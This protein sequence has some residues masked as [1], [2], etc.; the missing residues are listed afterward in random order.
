MPRINS[1]SQTY[2]NH[3]ALYGDKTKCFLIGA[4]VGGGLA[5]S[6]AL[7]LVELGMRSS[8]I[9]IVALAP[10]TMHPEFVPDEFKADFVAYSENAE[11]PLIDRAAMYTFNGKYDYLT[12]LDLAPSVL[13]V[14]L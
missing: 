5:L 2:K 10:I 6:V 4:S 12:L 1:T 7:K 11:R 14:T 13:M 8:I 9:G 3:E